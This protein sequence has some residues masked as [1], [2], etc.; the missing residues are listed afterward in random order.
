[1]G[2]DDWPDSDAWEQ[3][4]H[5]ESEDE[6]FGECNWCGGALV[7]SDDWGLVCDSCGR[8]EQGGHV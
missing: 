5:Q 8:D 1:M 3:G 6:C 7:V 2:R 4:F